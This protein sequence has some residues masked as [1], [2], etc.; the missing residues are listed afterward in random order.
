MRLVLSFDRITTDP[1]MMDGAPCIR[2]LRLPVATVVD[3]AAEG[4]TAADIVA[5]LRDLEATDVEQALHFAAE[6][7]LQRDAVAVRLGCL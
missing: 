2:G 5:A 6:S 1:G 7:V 3:M 4:M